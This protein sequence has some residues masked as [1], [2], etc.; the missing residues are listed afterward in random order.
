M[1]GESTPA[2]QTILMTGAT[3]GL[4]RVAAINLL[5]QAPHGHLVV[6]RSGGDIVTEELRQASGNPHPS[7]VAAGL[8]S[9][10]S[11]RAAAYS[12]ITC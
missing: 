3:R 1:P 7:A 12:P 9:V 6:A 11:T 8:A 4:G 5:R 2:T 10:G